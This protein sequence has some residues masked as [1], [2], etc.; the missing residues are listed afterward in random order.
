MAL[1][2]LGRGRIMD[3]PLALLGLGCFLASQKLPAVWWNYHLTV[4]KVLTSG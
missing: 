4:H 3:P 2:C 1:L